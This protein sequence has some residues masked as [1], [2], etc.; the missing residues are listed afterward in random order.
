[1]FV[2]RIVQEERENVNSPFQQ[3]I[4]NFE[5]GIAYTKLE[6]GLTSEFNQIMSEEYPEE[7]IDNVKAIV[8]GQNGF[9]FFIE[10]NTEL[11][12]RHYFIMTESGQSFERIVN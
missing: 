5:L 4:E 6:K 11:K 7:K 9:K 3:V 10:R 12:Q 1:M 8:C 2:L